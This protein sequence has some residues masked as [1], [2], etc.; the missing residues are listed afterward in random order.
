MGETRRKSRKFVKMPSFS[1]ANFWTTLK[2]FDAYAKPMD[3]F[4]IRTRSGGILTVLSGLMMII[5]FASEFRDYLQ[6]QMKEELF[7]D[8][9]R[10]GKLKI[11]VDVIF[12]RISCDFLGIDAMDISGEQHIDIEHNIYKRRLDLDGKPIEDAQKEHHLGAVAK[13][14]N[15][16]KADS[17]DQ[18]ENSTNYCGSCFGAKEGC[19]N[20]CNDVREAY[21]IKTWKFDPRGIEQCR[22]GLGSEV[23]ERALKEGCQIYGYLEVNRVGGSFHIAPGKSFIINHVHVHDVN[24]FASTDFNLTHHIR[25]VSFGQQLRDDQGNNQALNPLDDTLA[26]AE[27]GA[28]MFQYYVKIVPTTYTQPD[29]SF[30]PSN[31]FS[32]TRHS[33]VV[34]VMAGESG[35]PGVFFTYELSPVMVKFSP[36]EKSVGHFLTGLCAIIGGVFTVAGIL[37]KLIYTST[38]LIEQKVELGKAT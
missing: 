13:F 32:V 26:V 8:T 4:R 5:L 35:M 23:E 38:R 29:G 27:K 10:T 17:K 21:R 28:M 25:H 33:K 15:N 34:S 7:V 31:Q 9:S 3:D 36:K 24:P 6:P 2:R 16:T 19:C 18:K 12:S 22:E 20:T 30:F 14:T 37:D 11:N 1:A